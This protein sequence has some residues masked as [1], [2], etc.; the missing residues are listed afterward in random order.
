[1]AGGQK[2]LG[3]KRKGTRPI[4]PQVRGEAN[5]GGKRGTNGKQRIFRINFL[6]G[7]TSME[8][9]KENGGGGKGKKVKSM[10]NEKERKSN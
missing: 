5:Q 8:L 3:K 1:M 9:N 6:G 10:G 7:T 4:G 2:E